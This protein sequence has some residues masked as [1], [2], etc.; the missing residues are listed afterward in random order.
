MV[1]DSVLKWV[2][3]LVAL[4]EHSKAAL[5]VCTM[6]DY[7]VGWLGEQMVDLKEGS[8]AVESVVLMACSTE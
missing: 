4:M 6:V 1:A 5:S 7:S 8:R 3:H 2:D